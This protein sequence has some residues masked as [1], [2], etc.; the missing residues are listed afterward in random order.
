MPRGFVIVDSE[1]YKP[2]TGASTT[3]ST[4]SKPSLGRRNSARS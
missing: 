4:L 2:Q 3:S 1:R